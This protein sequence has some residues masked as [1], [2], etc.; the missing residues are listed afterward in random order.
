MH[1]SLPGKLSKRTSCDR[2]NCLS[3]ILCSMSG[4]EAIRYTRMDVYIRQIASCGI[5]NR[6]VLGPR[7]L[8]APA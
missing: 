7:F 6:I 3:M 1:R 2:I 8:L 5:G 4:L